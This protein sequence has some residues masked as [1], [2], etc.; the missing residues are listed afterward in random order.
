MPELKA[1]IFDFDGT[2]VESVGIKDEAFRELYS[3]YPEHLDEIMAYHLSHNHTVRFIKFRHI[4]ENILGKGYTTEDKD[5]LSEEFSRIVYQSIVECPFV[6]GAMELLTACRDKIAIYLV[7]KSPEEELERILDARGLQPYFTKV[8]P[9]SW[10]K[11]EAI[12]DILTRLNIHPLQAIYVGDA[13]EDR[14]AAEKEGV[15]F[16]GRDSGKKIDC[17]LVPDMHTVLNLIRE[18]LKDN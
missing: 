12:H 7:T 2:L 13:P 11:N 8:Y 14:I 10:E 6:P 1:I 4:S 3:G 16:I 9:A 17:E 5:M 18:E 15:R